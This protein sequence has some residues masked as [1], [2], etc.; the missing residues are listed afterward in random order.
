[1]ATN[2]MFPTG[3]TLECQSLDGRW[4]FIASG[5]DG[6]VII[7]QPTGEDIFLQPADAARLFLLM[8]EMKGDI[9]YHAAVYCQK[10]NV[11]GEETIPGYE[12]VLEQGVSSQEQEIPDRT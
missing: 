7:R 10:H 11:H 9:A 5:V 2:P 8:D 12:H 4:T 1:M 6:F 3:K